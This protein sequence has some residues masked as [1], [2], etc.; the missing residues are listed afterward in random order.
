MDRKSGT[1]A[2]NRA[3]MER[4]CLEQLQEGKSGTDAWNRAGTEILY[5]EQLHGQMHGT[6]LEQNTHEQ[7][8][9]TH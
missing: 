4:F 5:L 3:G 8:H 1:D 7:T 9:R 2:W 6:E